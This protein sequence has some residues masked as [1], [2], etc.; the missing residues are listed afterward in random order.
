[1]T[2]WLRAIEIL[3]TDGWCRGMYTNDKGE[4][5]IVGAL[6]QAN[7]TP[8]SNQGEGCISSFSKLE[9]M[10]SN[11]LYSIIDTLP[12]IYNDRP[13]RTKE[14]IIKLLKEMHDYECAQVTATE[15]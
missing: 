8:W 5:C 6:A 14:D 13:G 15:G 9:V 4:H 12:S 2:I 3:E 10:V 11:K 7:G 1:M